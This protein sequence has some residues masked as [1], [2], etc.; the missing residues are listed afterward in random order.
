MFPADEPRQKKPPV[1]Q[2]RGDS[3]VSP[4]RWSGRGSVHPHRQTVT[5]WLGIF[6]RP[7]VV[8][9]ARP[10]TRSQRRARRPSNAA[11]GLPATL[12][13]SREKAPCCDPGGEWP[14]RIRGDYTPHQ[15]CAGGG[16]VVKGP[17]TKRPP[18]ATLPEPGG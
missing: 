6:K 8:R 3:F 11:G 12:L 18:D 2:P 17:I 15:Y 9:V 14:S 13:L 16:A 5:P 1:V 7:K 4:N 10:S